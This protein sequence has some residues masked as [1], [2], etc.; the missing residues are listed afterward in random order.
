MYI[1]IALSR[2]QASYKELGRTPCND[3][4]KGDQLLNVK[5]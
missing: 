4:K 2:L 3:I 1:S 5:Q